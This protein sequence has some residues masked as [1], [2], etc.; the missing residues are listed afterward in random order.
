MP[1]IP[2]T[3]QIR[4]REAKLSN[5]VTFEGDGITTDPTAPVAFWGP[6]R[7]SPPIGGISC[8]EP[9]KPEAS[10]V[11]DTSSPNWGLMFVQ[12]KP[13]EGFHRATLV[14][15]KTTGPDTEITVGYESDAPELEAGSAP[16]PGMAPEF[17][18]AI[19]SEGD[20][21]LQV[22]PIGQSGPGGT[23]ILP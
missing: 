9:G 7:S 8:P 5:L 1:K 19:I 23:K 15:G 21:S 17:N 20:N 3:P 12:E 16:F 22:L 14:L 10:I 13:A 11:E 4:E 2:E 6:S 18:A